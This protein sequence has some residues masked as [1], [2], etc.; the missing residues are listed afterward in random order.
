MKTWEGIIVALDRLSGQLKSSLPDRYRLPY[1]VYTG[2][3]Y[4]RTGVK[5]V[6]LFYTG[7]SIAWGLASV[8]EAGV[9]EGP[10]V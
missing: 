4:R 3:R 10:P 1:F 8:E 2:C 7:T 6:I 5:E 9:E